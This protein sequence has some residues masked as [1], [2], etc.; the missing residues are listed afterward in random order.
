MDGIGPAGPSGQPDDKVIIPSR[1][2]VMVSGSADTSRVCRVDASD[3]LLRIWALLNR[4]DGELRQANLPPGTVARLQ[5]QFDVLTAELERSVSP[6]LA[7]E[8]RRLVGG[9]KAEAATVDELRLVYASLLG[10]T[11]GLVISMLSQLETASAKA[12]RSRS[13]PQPV[14]SQ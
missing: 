13:G 1:L 12:A 11:G 8:L 2:A 9:D 7:G 14:I 5:R 6:A 3:R 10:W 4:A